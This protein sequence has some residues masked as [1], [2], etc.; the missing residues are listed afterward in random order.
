MHRSRSIPQHPVLAVPTG[1]LAILAALAPP[2]A[3]QSPSLAWAGQMGGA[4]E[5]TGLSTAVDAAGNV[6]ATGIFEG[7]ADFD[8]G[9]GV[10]SLKSAGRNDV[11]I[12]KLDPDG[13]LLWA[14]QFAGGGEESGNSIAVDSTGNV[15]LSTA[16]SGSADF[17]PGPAVLSLAS[18][19]EHDTA[20]VKLDRV[21][22]LVWARQISGPDIVLSTSITV[23]RH[24]LVYNAGWFT[25]TADFDPGAAT[26]Q[27]TSVGEGD[28]FC[29]MLNSRGE[30]VWAAQIGGP[31]WDSVWGP[32]CGRR[33]ESARYRQLHAN[34]R[35]RR[36]YQFVAGDVVRRGRHPHSQDEQPGRRP[37]DVDRR[38]SI[39]RLDS[40][41][42]PRVHRLPHAPTHPRL[43]H[44]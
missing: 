30:F 8:P 15:Y 34:G 35:P 21:G 7:T 26:F 37:R 13:N 43:T 27:R 40:V 42:E 38:F 14:K 22:S 41:R 16:F 32:R 28:G 6:Y 44:A 10:F 1:A 19:G 33:G 3:G 29:S 39:R 9:P 12:T 36:L 11:W 18:A 24:G 20:I 5:E 17:D 23:D 2:S 4:Q 25:G 31:G